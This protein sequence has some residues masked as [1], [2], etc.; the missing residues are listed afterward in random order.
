ML[1][2]RLRKNWKQYVMTFSMYLINI[3][4]LQPALANQ[5]CSI[6]R[7]KYYGLITVFRSY[8]WLLRQ[9]WYKYFVN[10]C[11]AYKLGMHRRF[12]SAEY[13]PFLLRLGSAKAV[14]ESTTKFFNWINDLW[15]RLNS[16]WVNVCCNFCNT[17]RYVTHYL[18]SPSTKNI[19][20]AKWL[21]RNM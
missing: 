10:R 17:F 16:N 19:S 15:N 9:P 8:N 7:C 13:R 12:G 5:K 2:F 3:S 4:F 6:I 20:V 21:W 1:L 11:V 18:R 14:A